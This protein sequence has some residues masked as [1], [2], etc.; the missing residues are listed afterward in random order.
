MRMLMSLLRAACAFDSA[1]AMARVRA[2]TPVSGRALRQRITK[3]IFDWCRSRR[4][5]QLQEPQ[6]HISQ[7]SSALH[8]VAC[9]KQSSL[10]PIEVISTLAV[11]Q[12]TTVVLSR[13][14]AV[15]TLQQPDNP[16]CC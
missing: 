7:Y 15:E 14:L 1:T 16:P 12:R 4:L 10:H 5:P 11:E 2:I 13:L 8:A 9:R 3:H 6:T